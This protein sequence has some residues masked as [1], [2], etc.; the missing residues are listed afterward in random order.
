MLSQWTGLRWRAIP[1]PHGISSGGYTGT[2]TT[3]T[4]RTCAGSPSV[5]K[6]GVV[7][8]TPGHA[9]RYYYW[10]PEGGSDP[11]N[12]PKDPTRGNPPTSH[13]SYLQQRC[14]DCQ[15]SEEAT[16]LSLREKLREKTYDSLFGKW[17]GW[18]SERDADPISC[19]TGL[20]VNFLAHL[21]EQGY[22]YRSLKFLPLS[23]LIHAWEG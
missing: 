14:Q 11:M 10:S 12:T 13:V 19:P 22:Q 16:K 18:C 7:P 4:S 20:V 3:A 23:Y 5:E 21:F 9:G 1:T 2:N 8:S 6:P 17:V 15:V